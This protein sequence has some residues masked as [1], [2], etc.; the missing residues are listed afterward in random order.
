MCKM[1][2]VVNRVMLGNRELGWE[3]WNGKNIE[4][5]TSKQLQ[6]MIRG[7]KDKVYGLCLGKDGELEADAEG[8]FTTS[9]MEHRHIGNYRPMD[10]ESLVNMA[11]I[12]YGTD[13]VEG[14]TVYKCISNKFEQ[15]NLTD[16]QI[17]A[18]L[19]L[20]VLTGGARLKD[21]RI[22]VAKVEVVV[23][24]PEEKPVEPAKDVNKPEVK[25]DDKNAV[26]PV[27]KDTAK[28]KGGK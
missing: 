5:Y 4:E 2:V 23:K 10:S 27:T 17:K 3:T 20:G 22:E 21:G 12:C 26:T 8:F 15:V 11:Y 13:K 16:E 24:K 19:T 1:N 25:K 14:K 6:D 7:G 28:G 18:Y 9:V